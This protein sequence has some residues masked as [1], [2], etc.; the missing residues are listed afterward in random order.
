M[1]FTSLNDF[2]LMGKHAAFVW[3][4]FGISLIAII[5]I[6]I[7]ARV[8]HRHLSRTLANLKTNKH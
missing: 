8:R 3:S 4:A 1:H 7:Y 6:Q 2:F 5:V